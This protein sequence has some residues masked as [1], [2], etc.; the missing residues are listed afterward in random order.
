MKL[1]ASPAEIAGGP[2]WVATTTS[3]TS[4]VRQ[5]KLAGISTTVWPRRSI[6]APWTAT[7]TAF[8]ALSAAAA[9][10]APRNDPLWKRTRR[11]TAS[12]S[13]PIGKPP[14]KKLATMGKNAPWARTT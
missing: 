14:P 2:P 6:N 7:P 5:I 4:E 8:P 1:A 11:R 13:I 10:P 12:V 3:V 9:I